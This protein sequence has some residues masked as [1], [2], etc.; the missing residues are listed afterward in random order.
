VPRTAFCFI[1]SAMIGF[2][3]SIFPFRSRVSF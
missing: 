1:Q 3:V 2:I